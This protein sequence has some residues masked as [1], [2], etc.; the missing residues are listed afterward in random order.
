MTGIVQTDTSKHQA[1]G[2]IVFV[3]KTTHPMPQR[4]QNH[5]VNSEMI[6]PGLNE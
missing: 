5:A 6:N 1:S 3:D 4:L 2:N